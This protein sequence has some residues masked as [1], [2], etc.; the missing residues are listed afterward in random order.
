MADNTIGNN[1]QLVYRIDCDKHYTTA[2]APP[3][4]VLQKDSFKPPIIILEGVHTH[5]SK[6]P[7]IRDERRDRSQGYILQDERKP[8]SDN[9]TTLPHLSSN[10]GENQYPYQ[11]PMPALVNDQHMYNQNYSMDQSQDPSSFGKYPSDLSY[12]NNADSSPWMFGGQY[13]HRQPYDTGN[14]NERP[15]SALPSESG[16]DRTNFYDVGYAQNEPYHWQSAFYQQGPWMTAQPMAPQSQPYFENSNFGNYSDTYDDRIYGRD[17]GQTMPGM[18]AMPRSTH[19][20]SSYNNPSSPWSSYNDTSS[21][22]MMMPMQENTTSYPAWNQYEYPSP[23]LRQNPMLPIQ[24]DVRQPAFR[25]VNRP[26]RSK[27]V[28]FAPL[29]D[30]VTT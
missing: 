4:L 19:S 30:H 20:N 8:P 6:T 25:V 3:I 1:Q 29:P 13:Q 11:Q 26:W 14:Y 2:G 5:P 7:I 15:Y 12:N 9:A 24:K 16:N 21:S 17:E 23:P 22:T 10:H 18:P 28:S 27:S